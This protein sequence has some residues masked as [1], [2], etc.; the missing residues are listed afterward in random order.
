MGMNQLRWKRAQVLLQWYAVATIDR[1]VMTSYFHILGLELFYIIRNSYANPMTHLPF[2]ELQLISMFQWQHL[3]V[4]IINQLYQILKRELSIIVGKM[5]NLGHPAGRDW[6]D[7]YISMGQR[8]KLTLAAT[9]IRRWSSKR[10]SA[11]ELDEKYTEYVSHIE[12]VL[13]RGRL[14]QYLCCSISSKKL[15]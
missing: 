13:L 5:K 14:Q 12:I 15:S 9:V 4:L 8:R 1:G 2:P 7:H 10:Q 6:N 11:V 3:P